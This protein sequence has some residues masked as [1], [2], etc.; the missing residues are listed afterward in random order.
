MAR[1]STS[2]AA[3]S[4]VRRTRRRVATLPSVGI[5]RVSSSSS[6]SP[7]RRTPEAAARSVGSANGTSMRPPGIRRL[8]SARASLRHQV[9]LSRIAT[10]LASS[11]ASS[12]CW[13]VR[14]TVVPSPTRPRTMSHMVR[15]LRGSRPV[16][17]SSRKMISGARS[18]SSPG[19]AG[20]ASRRST[21]R[22]CGQPPRPVRSARATPRFVGA[23][24]AREMVEVGHQHEVLPPGEQIVDGREL[25]GHPIAAR[26]A[27]ASR[28]TS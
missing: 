4:S 22:P 15:R 9:A 24:R 12:R 1:L 2:T 21:C 3:S 19:P 17:G 16:V 18:A 20:A 10:W 27:S 6:P 26:T 7:V 25:P 23:L 13:V 8:S 14:N 28:A 11:S 5:C